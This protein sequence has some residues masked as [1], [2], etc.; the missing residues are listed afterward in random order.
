MKAAGYGKKKIDAAVQRYTG[1]ADFYRQQGK[2]SADLLAMQEALQALVRERNIKARLKVADLQKYAANKDRIEG[3]K[4]SPGRAAVSMIENDPRS[5]GLSY[6]TYREAYRGQLFALMGD[7]LGKIGKG[8]FGRQ[9]NKAH[10]P[11]VV[12]EIYGVN[13]GDRLAK[14]VAQA[15]T[16]TQEASVDLFNNAGGFMAKRADYRLPNPASSS[17]K[18]VRR[19]FEDFKKFHENALDWGRMQYPDG[20]PVDRANSDEILQAVYNTLSTNGASKI[21]PRS[22]NGNGAAMGKQLDRHRFLIYKDSDAWLEAHSRFGDGNVFDVMTRHVESMAHN[23]AFIRQFGSNPEHAHDTVRALAMKQAAAL[24]EAA[25]T[26]K[27]T[28]VSKTEA[29]LKNKFEPMWEVATRDNPMDPDSVWGNTVV[30]VSNLLTAAQLGSASLLAVSGDMI[31]SLNTRAAGKMPLFDGVGTYFRSLAGDINFQRTIAAQS[32]FVHDQSVLATYA[33]QRFTGFN[34]IGPAVTRHMSEATMRLSLLAGHTSAARWTM[35]AEF[36]GLLARSRDVAFDNLPFVHVMRRY[37]ITEADWDAF[38]SQIQPWSPGGNTQFARPIDLLNTKDG[39]RLYELF[40]GMVF[41]ESRTGVPESTI[42]AAVFLKDTSRP[43]T[44]VGA[45]LHSFAMYKNFPVSFAMIYGRLAMSLDGKAGK[46]KFLAGLGAGMTLVGA[47]GTQMRE[48]SKGRDP[49]PMNTLSFWGKAF[50]SGGALS[51]WGDFLFQGVNQF[52]RGPGDV[53]AGPLGQF[54]G[55]TTQ[56]ALGDLFQWAD[57]VGSLSPT[58][59]QSKTPA[60][61]VE[62]ARRY[63]PGTSIWWA[64][65][66]LERQVWDRLQ[67]LADPQGYKKQRAR[68]RRQR[69][70]FG[71]D[72]FFA[73]GSTSPDRGPSFEGVFGQ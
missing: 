53:M 6:S 14:N 41:E 33:A 21:N 34:T 63:T 31:Q 72:Y 68:V 24:D 22:F 11:N 59:F 16:K 62:F 73:P 66:A 67:L 65:L 2:S 55:D 29:I 27:R 60:K 47:M 1:L 52:G 58:E 17:A 40:Q 15:W 36:M 56:L 18:I 10:L 8:A 5:G 71:N 49:L 44:V 51:I 61:A 3:G 12:R 20:S 19:G 50:L 9:R 64:R 23:I 4:I 37:G 38:R 48:I 13:T 25:P 46:L 28:N 69:R 26:G 42:E 57:S 7:V 32:G 39:Q 35:Q 43:D 30:G 54:A 45:L 70:E